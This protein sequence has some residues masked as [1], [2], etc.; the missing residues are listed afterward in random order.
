MCRA[1]QADVL[2]V[3]YE[4]RRVRQVAVVKVDV[5]PRDEART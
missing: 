4:Q 3:G 2:T 1:L 5:R